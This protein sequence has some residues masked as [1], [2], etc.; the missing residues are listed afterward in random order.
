MADLFDN[1]DDNGDKRLVE[2]EMPLLCRHFF[3]HYDTNLDG[4]ATVEEVEFQSRIAF[5]HLEQLNK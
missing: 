2:K 1:N 5:H 3:D 4:Y